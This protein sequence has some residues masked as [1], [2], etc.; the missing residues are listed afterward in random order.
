[1][2]PVLLMPRISG[3]EIQINRDDNVNIIFQIQPK[4]N[5][6]A[7]ILPPFEPMK[8][9]HNWKNLFSHVKFTTNIQTRMFERKTKIKSNSP[10]TNGAVTS[11]EYKIK[12]DFF[13]H[14]TSS[15]ELRRS[16]SYI[17]FLLQSKL[18]SRFTHVTNSA[19]A[20]VKLPFGNLPLKFQAASS[21]SSQHGI[22]PFR[23]CIHEKR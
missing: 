22:A 12:F 9:F 17:F 20:A 4:N 3:K 8:Q 21:F 7:C 1:M 11:R 14:S 10:G 23:G 19:F 15:P 18:N 5:S 6:F 16:C 13:F 2:S